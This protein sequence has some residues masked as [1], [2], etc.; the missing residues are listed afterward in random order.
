VGS[1][2]AAFVMSGRCV[3]RCVSSEDSGSNGMPTQIVLTVDIVAQAIE[4]DFRYLPRL[5]N[6]TDRTPDGPQLI[7]L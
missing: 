3:R 7:A 1:L 6:E 4:R 2:R 5:G